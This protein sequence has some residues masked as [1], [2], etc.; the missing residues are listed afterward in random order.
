MFCRHSGRPSRSSCSISSLSALQSSRLM[1]RP[2]IRR[3]PIRQQMPERSWAST[4]E[5]AAPG[6]P[7][8]KTSTNRRSSTILQT[9]ETVIALSGV[10]LSPTALR[11]AAAVL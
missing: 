4:V 8:S 3:I 11:T 7:I 9:E 10:L 5:T 1:E 6:I 2:G